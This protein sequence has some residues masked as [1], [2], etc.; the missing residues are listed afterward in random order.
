MPGELPLCHALLEGGAAGAALEPSA[1]LE[2]RLAEIAGAA[3]AA[4]PQ[5]RLSR[6]A[7][8]RYLGEKIAA[9]ADGA[10]AL[11]AVHASDLFLACACARGLAGAEAA[12]DRE[13]SRAVPAALARMAGASEVA[14]EIQQDLREKMLLGRRGAEPGI[15]GY[16]GTG[17]LGGFLRICA[18]R[19]ALDRR[20]KQPLLAGGDLL[21]VRATASDPEGA[22]LRKSCR[23][24]FG[25]A[26]ERAL[27]ELSPRQ[28][29]ML[30]MH[31]VDRL[32]TRKIGEVYRID[33]SNAARAIA[34]A[35]ERL[36]ERTVAILADKLRMSASQVDGVV[37]LAIGKFEITLS[38]V[39]RSRS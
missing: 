10:R 30:R 39:L 23:R 26:F 28:R 27:G 32:T 11:E 9:K 38:R 12:L 7:F 36:R 31:Y 6:P 19:A 21:E 8:V 2:E 1:R 3:E 37:G 5:L 13:L 4:W 15:A 29:V 22:L 24:E 17:P 33:Q 14:D 16:S 18:Q 34:A 35:R 25:S 20:R